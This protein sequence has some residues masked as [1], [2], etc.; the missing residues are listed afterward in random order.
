MLQLALRQQQLQAAQMQLKLQHQSQLVHRRQHQSQQQNQL[1]SSIPS[2]THYP[3]SAVST[4]SSVAPVSE[5]N[6]IVSSTPSD[7]MGWTSPVEPGDNGVQGM[8]AHCE[9]ADQ[10]NRN[11]TMTNLSLESNSQ[12]NIGMVVNPE[13]QMLSPNHVS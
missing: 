10:A 4:A 2:Q 6:R 12:S 13:A 8:Q 9:L 11:I 1:Q 7:V 5:V 3:L